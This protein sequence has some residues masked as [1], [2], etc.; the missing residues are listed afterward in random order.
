VH[1]D[2]TVLRVIFY[3]LTTHIFQV[4]PNTK[5]GSG[6]IEHLGKTFFSSTMGGDP[7]IDH[8]TKEKMNG[9]GF[10]GKIGILCSLTIPMTLIWLLNLRFMPRGFLCLMVCI[11]QPSTT[12]IPLEI[13]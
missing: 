13:P 11:L 1:H 5:S 2:F 9:P 6:N 3:I 8:L 10:Q 12:L 7:V 4:I